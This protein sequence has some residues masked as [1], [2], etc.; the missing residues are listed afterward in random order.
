MKRILAVTDGSEGA[1]RAIDF[2]ADLAGRL[3]C[4]LLVLNVIGGH[5]LP[6][7]VMRKMLDAQSAWFDDL[8]A[9]NS[10][11]ILRR[12]QDRVSALGLTKTILESRRGEPVSTMI[13]YAQEQHVDAIFV[14]KR[15]EGQLEA[16][17]LG[18]VSQKLVSLAPMAVMVVP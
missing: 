4:D 2:A 9:A 6:G 16:V 14:G 8:L 13:D 12:A 17:L 5:D 15:G 10:A 3:N 11:D 7:G 18:S 1:A